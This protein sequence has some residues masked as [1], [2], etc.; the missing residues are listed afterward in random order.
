MDPVAEDT[1]PA[2]PGGL[3]A[4]P[5]WPGDGEWGR[6]FAEVRGHV[7]E[8]RGLVGLLRQVDGGPGRHEAAAQ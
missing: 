4:P 2:S 5:A 8:L 3:T 6:V 1:D 7:A